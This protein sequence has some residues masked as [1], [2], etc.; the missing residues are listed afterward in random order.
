MAVLTSFPPAPADA[1]PLPQKLAA[2]GLWL[3][4][5]TREMQ[6]LRRSYLNMNQGC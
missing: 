6:S 3:V 2:T 4:G 5:D 1:Q